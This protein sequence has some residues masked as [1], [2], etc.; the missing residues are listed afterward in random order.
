MT[1]KELALVAGVSAET[2]RRN[3]K[4]LFPS[5]FKRGIKTMFTKDQCL[6]IMKNTNRK[7]ALVELDTQEPQKVVERVEPINY[8]DMANAMATAMQSIMMPMMEKL[9]NNR[10]ALPEPDKQDYY[11][12][13][14]YCR[15]K[16]ITLTFSEKVMH[17]KKLSNICKSRDM[18]LR[19]VPDERFGFVNSYPLEILDEHFSL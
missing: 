6:E 15:F 1:V 9:L 10:K 7:N 19:Q 14:G 3:G 16:T 18:K 11:S 13:T 5:L 12:L 2:I 8:Q 17:G 4:K